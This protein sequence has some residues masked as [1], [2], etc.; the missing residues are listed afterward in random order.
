MEAFST[1]G[2][3]ALFTY[4]F[5]KAGWEKKML[6]LAGFYLGG[7]VIPLIPW[8]FAYG[9]TAEMVRRAAQEDDPELPEWD[10]WNELLM[11]G[12]RL[13]GTTLIYTIPLV[14]IFGFGFGSYF[15]VT[16]GSIGLAERSRSEA[17][18]LMAILG[19]FGVFMCSMICGTLFAICSG[20]LLPAAITHTVV[21]RS[22]AAFFHIGEWWRIL[23]ANM[24]GY[25]IFFILL[26]GVLFVWQL[27]YSLLAMTLLLLPVAFLIPILTAPY[28]SA[29][30]AIIL[31]R[32]YREAQENLSISATATVPAAVE[33]PAAANGEI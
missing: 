13:M 21:K 26:G 25:V 30:T 9:Y 33:M 6:I 11:D 4:P 8:L 2:L 22:F 17:W 12:L 27:F 5:R 7:L 20:L 15:G 19:S 3:K 16:L 24:G 1:R 14:L 32:V 28:F 23:R 31:G 10:N 18:I 29:L